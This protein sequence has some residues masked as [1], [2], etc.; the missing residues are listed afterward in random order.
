MQREPVESSSIKSVG[1][2]AEQQ[3]LEVE[4]HSGHIYQYDGITEEQHADFMSA[5]SIG[6]HFNNHIMGQFDSRRL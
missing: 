6:K 4:F 5:P 2:D 1:H 3:I